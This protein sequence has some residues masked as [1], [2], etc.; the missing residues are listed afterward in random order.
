LPL[1]STDKVSGNLSLNYSFEW[2]RN[3]S[4]GTI[5]RD[6]ND[7]LPQEPEYDVRLAGLSMGWNHSTRR[8][9]AFSVGPGQG[10][11]F[12]AVLALNHPSLGADFRTLGLGWQWEYFYKLP[13]GKTPV[14]ALRLAGGLNV[15]NRRRTPTFSLGGVPQQDI[16]DAIVNS[17]RVATS[18]Y[19]RGYPPGVARGTQYHLGN[20][21][22]RHLLWA[23]E[24]GYSTL[25]IYFHRLHIAGLIDGGNAFSGPIDPTEF[26]LAA[27]G[28]V[29]LDGVF[30]YFIPGTFEIGYMRGFTD[31]GL[32]QYWFLLT[33]TI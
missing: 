32:G 23:V 16:V 29:R 19:L 15:G 25:P 10:H 9:Y 24:R 11:A 26:K 22:Y 27:G 8:G 30:G 2:I 18:G 28:A 7:T 12:S 4:S 14:L 6:P 20:I 1:L 17:T 33:A 13:W 5:E 3:T 31:G 21:E